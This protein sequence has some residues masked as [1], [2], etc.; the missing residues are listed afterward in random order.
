MLNLGVSSINYINTKGPYFNGGRVMNSEN[1][2]LISYKVLK[3]KIIDTGLCTACGACEAACP[4]EALHIKNDTVK[5]QYNC[6]EFLDLCPIC[7]AV[8]PHSEALLLRS[9]EAVSDAPLKSGVIGYYRKIFLAQA[10]DSK[11][12]EQCRGSGVVTALLAHGVE[13]NFFDSAIVSVTDS[14]DS[15][16]PKPMV[17]VVPDDV[18][19]A[20]GS[21]FFPSA[22]LSAYGTAVWGY[23]KTKI[24]VVGVPCHVLALRKLAAWQHKISQEL[25]IVIGLFCFGTF[26]LKPLQEYIT[27]TYNLK[28]SDIKQM[29][30]AKDLIVQTKKGNITIPFE[31]AQEKVL[32]SCQT[33]AD[34]TAEFADISVG[35]AFPMADWS[36]VIIRTKVGEEFFYGATEKGIINVH[37]I[38]AEPK[39]F[40]RVIQPAIKKRTKALEAANKF[41]RTHGFIPARLIRETDLLTN[42]KVEDIMT[43]T[44]RTVRSDM[45][46]NELLQRMT[47]EK[48]IGYPVINEKGELAGI[49]TI[50]EVS[51]VNKKDRNQTLVS[52]I[53]RPNLN[54]AYPGETAA[55]AFRKMSEQ[56]TGRI[57]V[58]DPQNPNR[59]I[60]IVTKADL[61]HA[62]IRQTCEIPC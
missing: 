23:G 34:F 47:I 61:L 5:R 29:R 18:F 35:S 32:P 44:V 46:V 9:L 36:V 10:A 37:A 26:S 58:L 11:L 22:V 42:V 54:I 51:A 2:S 21:K 60:G 17:A 3:S 49:V 30:L 43:R 1:D 40:E 12:R 25:K 31:V 27:K 38:E 28:L 33:C 20:S 4:I 41:A 57:L 16:K 8:C 56:E 62:L 52:A 15:T 19:S 48:Q 45:T 50:E 55:D 7:Y 14:D 53:T 39:V 13:N 6:A 24:A 59:I